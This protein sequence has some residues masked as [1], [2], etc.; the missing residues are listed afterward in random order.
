M[1]NFQAYLTVSIPWEHLYFLYAQMHVQPAWNC[2]LRECFLILWTHLSDSFLYPFSFYLFW[3]WSFL[4]SPDISVSWYMRRLGVTCML[5]E[6]MTESLNYEF[7][8][9]KVYM[10]LECSG[11]WFGFFKKGNC[12]H[13]IWNFIQTIWHLEV[14]VKNT[15]GCLVVSIVSTF[16]STN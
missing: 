11:Q 8:M 10:L 15:L 7:H 6:R 2:S 5:G 13:R 9:V 3:Y 4:E 16:A 14:I 12:G 1:C